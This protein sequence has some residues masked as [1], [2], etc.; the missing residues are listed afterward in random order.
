VKEGE[1]GRERERENVIFI[2]IVYIMDWVENCISKMKEKHMNLLGRKLP[3]F[4][5]SMMSS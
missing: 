4:T 5:S 1:G 2:D 3:L